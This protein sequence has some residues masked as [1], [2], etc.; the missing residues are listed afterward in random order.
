MGVR[1]EEGSH[2]LALVSRRPIERVVTFEAD[3]RPTAILVPADGTNGAATELPEQT[4]EHDANLEAPLFVK[5]YDREHRTPFE[6]M[7][8][9]DPHL[10]P[11]VKPKILQ[12]IEETR[13]ALGTLGADIYLREWIAGRIARARTPH[14]YGGSQLNISHVQLHRLEAMLARLDALLE[15]SVAGGSNVSQKYR[16]LVEVIIQHHEQDEREDKPFVAICFVTRRAQTITVA[17][18]LGLTPEVQ[19]FVR[20]APLVGHGG[21]DDGMEPKRQ[22]NIV[23]QLRTGELNVLVATSVAEE[24]AWALTMDSAHWRRPRLPRVFARRAV[25]SRANAAEV[26][27]AGAGPP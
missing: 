24:G 1:T 10:F 2:D 18:L 11:L 23:A 20:A 5:R 15:C 12:Q 19:S 7:I 25:R 13:T 26:R 4:Y 16:K 6:A 27:R 22:E 9:D 8:M 17:T 14:A 21:A 3:E